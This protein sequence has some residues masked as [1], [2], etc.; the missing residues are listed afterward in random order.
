MGN[1][2][3]LSMEERKEIAKHLRQNSDPKTRKSESDKVSSNAVPVV[4]L[5]RSSSVQEQL[6]YSSKM[7]RNLKVQFP[8]QDSSYHERRNSIEYQQIR[9]NST[10]GTIHVVN[11]TTATTLPESEDDDTDDKEPIAPD[12]GYG[13][14]VMI[15]SFFAS[16]I[17]DGVCFAFGIFYLEFLET[18][19]E[20]RSKTAWIGSV[21]NGMYM[22]TGKLCITITQ[23]LLKMLT[24]KVK[25]PRWY[26]TR[27]KHDR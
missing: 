18:F 26:Q 9:R 23:I 11:V 27:F 5:Q 25:C 1:K 17:V 3:K 16:V 19:Q 8:R 4:K 10:T 7:R 14:V 21:L 15:A 12:G 24:K 2:D 20:D 22:V 6:I 13:W